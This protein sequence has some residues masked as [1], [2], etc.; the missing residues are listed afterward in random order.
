MADLAMKTA[1]KVQSLITMTFGGN[2]FNVSVHVSD[3]CQL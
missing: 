3:L 2:I 1:L